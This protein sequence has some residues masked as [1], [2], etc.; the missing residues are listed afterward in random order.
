M[1]V[2]R[3]VAIHTFDPTKFQSSPEKWVD[4]ISVDSSSEQ[5]ASKTHKLLHTD[6]PEQQ[7]DLLPMLITPVFSIYLIMFDLR[8]QKEF[9]AKIH[10]VLKDVYTISSYRSEAGGEGKQ[11][12]VFLVGMHADEVE[13]Q[14]RSPFAQELDKRLR[15]MP[16]DSLIRKPHG[17]EPFWA[18]NG[19]DLSLSGAG[20]LPKCI[21][22]YGCIH[23]IEVL[24]W[25]KH[26][27]ELQKKHAPCILYHELEDEVA[28]KS[29]EVAY[30][31]KLESQQFDSFLQFLHN[32]NLIF[33]H[34][35][36]EVKKSDTVIL[37]QPQELCKI[38][39]KVRE[40]SEGEK[41]ER[42]SISDLFSRPAACEKIREKNRQWFQ[43]VCIDMGLVVKLRA[44][45]VFLMCC[46]ASTGLPHRDE[47]SVPP[48]LIAF[49]D[50]DRVAVQPG[51]LVP[52]FFFAAFVTEFL[53]ALPQQ[54]SRDLPH[55]EPHYMK[56]LKD[57]TYIHVVERE[58]CI[59]IGVQ[60]IDIGGTKLT[61]EKKI[62]NLLTFCKEIRGQMKKCVEIIQGRLNLKPS[63]IQYGFYHAHQAGFGV[64]DDQPDE[65]PILHCLC[66]DPKMQPATPLQKIWFQEDSAL[67]MKVCYCYR[68]LSGKFTEQYSS[69]NNRR[70]FRMFQLERLQ[71]VDT[72]S[73]AEMS[74]TMHLLFFSLY[75]ISVIVL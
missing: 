49:N 14:D 6:F 48:L 8:N 12:K 54:Q 44:E 65:D 22:S 69:L 23:Q 20:P 34:T 2:T 32:Y 31:S 66:C 27:D 46:K 58:V 28:Q 41:T 68:I 5:V 56:A 57:K 55:I 17:S 62:E 4:C 16:Y 29:S 43:S 21:T 42:Y 7:L 25:M 75:Q 1:T 61:D 74:H 13:G 35:M 50:P 53:E 47:Y 59:E 36:K 3:C 24:Q 52:A 64:L 10:S 73:Q 9:L 11:P 40:F 18:V 70:W 30:V 37:L 19:G 45:Y 67:L 63:S 26:H 51:Y 71:A 15:E 60:Q 33:Y 39:A 72:G 38:F